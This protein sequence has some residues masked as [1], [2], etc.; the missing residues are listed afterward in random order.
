MEFLAEGNPFTSER[1]RHELGWAPGVRPEVG[2]PDAF[3]W[4][5]ATHQEKQRG[6][7]WVA[8]TFTLRCVPYGVFVAF[9]VSIA[10]ESIF[11]PVSVAGA[12]IAATRAMRFMEILLELREPS[13]T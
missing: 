5:A 12:K 9:V 3:A 7:T 11:M 2:V 10:A 1:A 6:A 8:P 4:W 13:R